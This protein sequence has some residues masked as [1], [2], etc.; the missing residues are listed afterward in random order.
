M[1]KKTNFLSAYQLS[2]ERHYLCHILTLL[3][4]YPLN[5][6][7]LTSGYTHVKTLKHNAKKQS[8]RC[9]FCFT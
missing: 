2:S 3:K 7:P 1:S 8:Y 5:V 4:F 6:I 9:I